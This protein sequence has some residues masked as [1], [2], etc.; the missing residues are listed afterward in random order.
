MEKS[1][2]QIKFEN[3]CAKLAYRN[4]SNV[5][6]NSIQNICYVWLYSYGF[7]NYD[8]CR[9]GWDEKLNKGKISDWGTEFYYS[10]DEEKQMP[11]FEFPENE[12]WHCNDYQKS[13]LNGLN[14]Y[15]NP[16]NYILNR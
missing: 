8:T 14:K 6:V 2:E 4:S 15:E 7:K 9:V 11:I 10:I 1:Q 3:V 16:Y 5:P 13:Y 12:Y